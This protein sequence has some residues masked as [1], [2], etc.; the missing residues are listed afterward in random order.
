MPTNKQRRDAA[1]RHLERQLQ[2]RQ[3]REA[4]RRKF[5]LIASIA[6]TV[7]LVVAIALVIRREGLLVEGWIIALLGGEVLS[8]TLKRIIHRP[9]P[10]FSV[11]LTSQSWSFPSGHA[12]E[13]LVAYGM[14]A[15]LMITLLPGTRTRR[16]VIILGATTLILAIGFSRMYLGVHYFSDVVGGFAAGA[17][18][19]AMCISGLEVARGWN[20]LDRA[21]RWGE[22]A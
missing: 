21:K 12:M 15:Y 11:I 13:S 9:R 17:L 7:G 22:T 16:R 5:T 10:P 20:A 6:G 1:R 18:W 8:E 3:E 4:F 14:A 19:L 2:R